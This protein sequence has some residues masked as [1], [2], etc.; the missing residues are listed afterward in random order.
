MAEV[1]SWID[2]LRKMDDVELASTKADRLP[3]DKVVTLVNQ[4]FGRRER[5]H[6]HELNAQLIANQVR[7]M[8]FSMILGSAATI[9]GGIVG[10][11]LALSLQKTPSSALTPTPTR[12][13]QQQ[14]DPSTSVDRNEKPKSVPSNTY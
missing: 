6:Q 7:W 3:N 11:V 4:E 8:T 14:N 5:V 1:E 9:I 2:S 13:T 10:I 12:S